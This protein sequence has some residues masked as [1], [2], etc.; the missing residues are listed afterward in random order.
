MVNIDGYEEFLSVQEFSKI[1]KIHPNTV[2][3]SIKNGRLSAFRIGS[4]KRSDYRI[5]RSEIGRISM[6]DLEKIVNKMVQERLSSLNIDTTT[7]IKE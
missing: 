6:I 1:V 3:R 7:A 5:A 4:G 2:R